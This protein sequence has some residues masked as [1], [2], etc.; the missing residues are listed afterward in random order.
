MKVYRVS[1]QGITPLLMHRFP[2]D[3][4]D[5]PGKRRSGVPDW[6]EEAERAL[7][8]DETGVIYEPATHIESALREAARNFKVSG[9][10]GATYFR[11]VGSTVTVSP[12]AIPH[13]SPDYQI[14]SR[15]VVVQKARVVRYRPRFDK[16]G[17]A[18]HIVCHDDQL[19][20]EIVKQ[21]LD[22]AGLYVGIGD[23][24]PGKGGKFGR[25]IV[26]RFEEQ[27]SK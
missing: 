27:T 15:P 3:G 1:V 25:F 11:L 19:P 26:T 22:Y 12:D 2:M 21:V 8:R 9:R 14:D 10:R 7:Y 4:A 17:L 23:F 13:D 24:R 20:G 18:F 5:S 16:W 6:K